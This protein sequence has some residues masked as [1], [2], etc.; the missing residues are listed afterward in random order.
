[1]RI[2]DW[3]SDLCSSDL[4]VE[5]A[6]MQPI[7]VDRGQLILE[8]LVEEIDDFFVALH[9]VYPVISSWEWSERIIRAAAPSGQGQ[10]WRKTKKNQAVAAASLMILRANDKIGRAHV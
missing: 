1:M 4:I 5:H 8:R 2:S 9:G 10:K 7:L 6:I 3:S